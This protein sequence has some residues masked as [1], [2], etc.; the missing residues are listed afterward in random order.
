MQN[1]RLGLGDTV[2]T[3]EYH[4]YHHVSVCIVGEQILNKQSHN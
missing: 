3:D 1:I 2:S 4:C